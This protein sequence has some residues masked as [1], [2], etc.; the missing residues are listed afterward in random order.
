MS[1]KEE[2]TEVENDKLLNKL[3]EIFDD[4]GT[5]LNYML[6]YPSIDPD[7]LLDEFKS[8]FEYGLREVKKLQKQLDEDTFPG[9]TKL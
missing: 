4:V 2:V 1:K 7:D 3:E 8:E 5:A 6:D 9:P